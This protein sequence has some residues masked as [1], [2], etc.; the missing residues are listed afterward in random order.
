M[1]DVG[2]IAPVSRRVESALRRGGEAGAAEAIRLFE[3]VDAR[4]AAD[5]TRH[6]A[7]MGV[8]LRVVERALP[9]SAGRLEWLLRSDLRSIGI[10]TGFD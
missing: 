7:A 3:S 1:P 6:V 10:A 9:L 2:Q 8:S 5:W 4:A